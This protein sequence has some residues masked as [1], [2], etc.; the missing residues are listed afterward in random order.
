MEEVLKDVGFED[1]HV[2]RFKW[3]TN[4]WPKDTKHKEL[5]I[6][7]FENLAPNLEGMFMASYT[8]GLHWK[9]EEVLVMVANARKDFA[10]RNIHAY[11]NM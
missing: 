1:V 3:P 6:W 9:K 11:F 4:N 8:R 2:E 10:N 7:N 5:G